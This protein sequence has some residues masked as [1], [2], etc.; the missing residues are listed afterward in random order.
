MNLNAGITK[1]AMGSID[2]AMAQAEKRVA[3]AA[4][5]LTPWEAEYRPTRTAGRKVTTPPSIQMGPKARFCWEGKR[6][7]VARGRGHTLMAGPIY[8]Q[9]GE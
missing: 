6:A 4:W 9:F 8:T 7:N 2:A 3:G 1:L 5:S